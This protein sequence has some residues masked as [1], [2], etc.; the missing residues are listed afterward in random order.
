M[1]LIDDVL[2]SPVA[3]LIYILREIHHAAQQDSANEAERIRT[4]LSELYMLLETT[5]ITEADADAREKKLLDRLEEI[6]TRRQHNGD[7]ED[8]VDDTDD[9]EEPSDDSDDLEVTERPGPSAED[10]P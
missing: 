4:E 10:G 1:F 7:D 6:E 9:D 2:L 3:G 5:Q 8:D